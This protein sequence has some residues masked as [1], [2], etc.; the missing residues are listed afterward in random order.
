MRTGGRSTGSSS[1]NPTNRWKDRFHRNLEF[2]NNYSIYVSRPTF[3]LL[4]RGDEKGQHAFREIKACLQ[5]LYDAEHE[6]YSEI[7]WKGISL[8][9]SFSI[10]YHKPEHGQIK[11][12]FFS[13]PYNVESEMSKCKSAIFEIECLKLLS[14]DPKVISPPAIC[15]IGFL[16]I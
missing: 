6:E 10:S 15:T 16:R 12:V 4:R 1:N 9:N 11:S 5:S 8:N 7:G 14:R 13:G 3:E 2:N